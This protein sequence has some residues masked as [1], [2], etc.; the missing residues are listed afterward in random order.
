VIKYFNKA[1]QEKKGFNGVQFQV[2]WGSQGRSKAADTPTVKSP[3]FH[4]EKQS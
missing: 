3:Q 4:P 1:T 2:L